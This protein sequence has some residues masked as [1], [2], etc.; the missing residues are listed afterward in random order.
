MA[1]EGE[2]QGQYQWYSQGNRQL[3]ASEWSQ[4]WSSNH[5]RQDGPWPPLSSDQKSWWQSHGGPWLL[6]SSH[7]CAQLPQAP[8]FLLSTHSSSTPSDSVGCTLSPPRTVVAPPAPVPSHLV[9]SPQTW[10][11]KHLYLFEIYLNKHHP[12]NH[13]WIN[14][15]NI[16]KN[17]WPYF[18][19][20]RKYLRKVYFWSTIMDRAKPP[21]V[22]LPSV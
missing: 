12:I 7:P 16:T 19:W 11:K 13:M 3:S 17:H 14:I 9:F 21:W 10:E 18:K 8:V 20:K 1:Q 4:S 5:R 2:R 22:G 6:L 15:A